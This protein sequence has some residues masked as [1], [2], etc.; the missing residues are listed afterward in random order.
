MNTN[1]DFPRADMREEWKQ[2]ADYPKYYISNRGRVLSTA[3][4]KTGRLIKH[5][6]NDKGYARITLRN[7]NG[8]KDFF[9]HRL[10]AEHFLPDFDA[11]NEVHHRDGNRQNNN[12]DNLISLVKLEHIKMHT[13][14]SKGS[15]NDA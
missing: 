1:I 3:Q 15:E 8:R 6:L 11:F 12:A 14:K 7:E 13:S 4:I 5:Y 2:I 9:V 10:V